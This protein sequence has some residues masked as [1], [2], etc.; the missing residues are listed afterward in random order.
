MASIRNLAFEALADPT[1]RTILRFLAAEGESSAGDIA[2]IAR[3]VSRTAVS[4][5]LRVLRAAGLVI[6]RKEGRFRLY[7]LD[8]SPSGEVVEFLARYALRP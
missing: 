8:L 4:N 7:S 3:T 5:H 6:Q 1:R 2:A